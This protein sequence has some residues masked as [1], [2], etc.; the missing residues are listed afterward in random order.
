MSRWGMSEDIGPVDLRDSE[1]HPFLGRE[2]AQPRHFSENSARAVDEAV[3]QLLKDAENRAINLIRQ[4]HTQLNNLISE[5]EQHET[6]SMQQ[7]QA[8]LGDKVIQ[9]VASQSKNGLQQ[10]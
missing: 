2:I 9:P 3:K 4:K 7:V 10:T 5:L 1:E 8:C 6:L